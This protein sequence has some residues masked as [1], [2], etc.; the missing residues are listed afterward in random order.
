MMTWGET[1]GEATTEQTKFRG[2]PK[3]DLDATPTFTRP[4]TLVDHRNEIHDIDDR[5]N[6]GASVNEKMLGFS[7]DAV[8]RSADNS[9]PR[10]TKKTSVMCDLSCICKPMM[11]AQLTERP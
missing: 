8:G 10:G 2:Q 1:Y 11:L 7:A 5:D 6:A 9:T 3:A 4:A